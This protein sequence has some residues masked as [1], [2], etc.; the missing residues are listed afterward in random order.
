MSHQQPTMILSQATVLTMDPQLPQAEAVA[1]RQGRIVAVG[2]NAAVLSR[3]GPAT[4]V[5]D[6]RGAVLLPGFVDAHL[7]LRALAATF[8]GIDCRPHTVRSLDAL[9]T[10]LRQQAGR[11]PPGQWLVGY[12]YDEFA[13]AERRHPTRW[14]LDIAAPQHPVRLAHRSRHAWVLN[15]LA[16]AQLGMTREFVAPDGGVVERDPASGEP[17]GLLIDMDAYLRAHLRRLTTPEMF[18][19][20]LKR[21][22]QALF[23]AGVTT[24]GEASVSNDL[25]SYDA[26]RA[27]IVDGD[28]GVRVALLM[29]ASTLPDGVEAD[30]NAGA[31]TPFLHLQGVKIRLDEAS[32]ELYPPPEVVN[33][34][35]WGAHRQGLP[36]AI[37][38]VEL[39]ALVAALRAI[40]LAQERLPRLGLRHRI[41]HCALCPEACMDEL[42]ALQVAVVTQPAFLWHHGQRYM[43]EVEPEQRPWLYRVKSFLDR[44]IPVA[45]SSDAPVV[46]PHPLRGV[47]AA[48]TRQTPD[49]HIIGPEERVS[50]A[51]ALRLFTRGAAWAC[52]LESRVGSIG[53][54]KRA[55]LVVLEADP[56]R[57]P[58][59]EIPQIPVR[60]TMVD[61]AV[62]W[63]VEA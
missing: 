61:G 44:G 57:V 18:R 46:P 16:L 37:H 51:E 31:A 33:A 24:I 29:G 48:V 26:F 58:P 63:G 19:S 9:Q 60:L 42:V 20:A 34:Q 14:D 17:T 28:V 21:A 35:V 50:V 41:E 45:G 22:S 30:L 39:P 40:R 27:W 49:G 23:A 56:R 12:G 43:T 54:G 62:R 53:R 8:L 10:L 5:V 52:G 32:G 2:T 1:V 6:C 36:V 55:D 3:R 11:I 59:D 15:S 7:H 25:A 13:L 47:Y 4:R 38:A